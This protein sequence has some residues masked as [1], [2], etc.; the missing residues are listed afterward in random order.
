MDAVKGI[1]AQDVLE[2]CRPI[3]TQAGGVR[4]F[5]NFV[6]MHQHCIGCEVYQGTISLLTG[7]QRRFSPLALGDVS[8]NGTQ[9]VGLAGFIEQRK[10]VSQEYMLLTVSQQCNLF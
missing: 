6:L 2:G 1:P 5:D 8:G 3:Q 10:L 9:C 4:V 7:Q